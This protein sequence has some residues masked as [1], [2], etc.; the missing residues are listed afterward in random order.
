MRV[1]IGGR[2]SGMAAVLSPRSSRRIPATSRPPLPPQVPKP[3][4]KLPPLPGLKQRDRRNQHARRTGPPGAGLRAPSTKHRYSKYLRA[5]RNYDTPRV[6]SSSAH[7]LFFRQATPPPLQLRRPPFQSL[8][9][10]RTFQRRTSQPQQPTLQP[11]RRG[12]P[13]LDRVPCQPARP[14][15]ETSAPRSRNPGIGR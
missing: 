14:S 3:P 9:R 7:H 13:P 1:F 2:E 11:R 4:K 8:R 15:R 6:S 5:A 10:R 12:T